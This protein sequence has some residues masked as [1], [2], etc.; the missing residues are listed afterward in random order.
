MPE[1]LAWLISLTLGGLIVFVL[2]YRLNKEAERNAA[3]LL[4]KINTL[5]EIAP[6]DPTTHNRILETFS[7]IEPRL[8]KVHSERLYRGVLSILEKAPDNINLRVFALE[9]GRL[10]H[11][12]QR[13]SAITIFDEQAIQNDILARSG[14]TTLDA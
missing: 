5:I 11:G 13:G 10:H 1:V 4:D 2:F 12:L 7:Q 14:K 9:T 6:T 8:Q 3:I